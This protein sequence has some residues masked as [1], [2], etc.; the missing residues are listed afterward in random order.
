LEEAE[1]QDTDGVTRLS[2]RQKIDLLKKLAEGRTSEEECARLCACL[3]RDR[4]PSVRRLA[5]E[6]LWGISDPRHIE[7]LIASVRTDDDVEVRA[8]AA[9]VLGTYVW[10]GLEEEVPQR[11]FHRVRRFLVEVVRDEGSPLPVRRAALE[12]VSFDPDEEVAELIEWG[13]TQADRELNLSAIFA[14][15]RS[16]CERWVKHLASEML[17]KDRER[18][19]EAVN[20]AGEGYLQSLTPI[21]R[22]MVLCPDRDIRIAAMWALAHSGGPGALE[23]LELC[24]ASSDNEVRRNASDAILEYQSV[25][26]GDEEDAEPEG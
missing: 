9:S 1:M 26:S 2:E 13:Y 8:S 7:P 16:Q 14:M 21:L 4:S 6:G 25:Y 3:M 18:A 10:R 11:H 23:Q 5:I 17:S 22:N 20:A 19:L 15:G 24:A 12:A